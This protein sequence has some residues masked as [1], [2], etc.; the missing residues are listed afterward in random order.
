MKGFLIGFVIW[1]FFAFGIQFI[2][3]W[4]LEI[5]YKWEK[6][7]APKDKEWQYND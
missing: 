6:K 7:H 5:R 2:N 1:F 4:L 3:A